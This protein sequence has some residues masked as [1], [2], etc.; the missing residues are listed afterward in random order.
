MSHSAYASGATGDPE[1]RGFIEDLDAILAEMDLSTGQ[2]TFVSRGAERLLGYPVERWYQDPEMWAMLLHPEDRVSALA[3]CQRETAAGRDHRMEYR[4]IT[5]DGRVV[6]IHDDVHIGFDAAGQPSHLRCVM[7][8]VTDRYQ[9]SEALRVSERW[10]RALN[11]HALDIVTVLSPQGVILYESPSLE[12]VLGFRPE[13]MVGRNAFEVLHPDDVAH[14]LAVFRDVLEHRV[15]T[16][17][18]QFRFPHKA[19]GWR[20]IEAYGR[21]LTSD[22]A[23]GGMVVNSRDVTDRH[24]AEQSLR[25]SETRYR[26]VVG[27]LSEGIVLM[28]ASGTVRASNDAAARIF[29]QSL[30][31]F[32][33]PRPEEQ[34]ISV[35]REDGSL[36]PFEERPPIR[37]LRERREVRDC[38]LG[39][40]SDDTGEVRWLSVHAHPLPAIDSNEPT[41]AV[42]SLTDITEQRRLQEVLVHTQKMEAVGRF[43]GG[44]AHDFNNLLTAVRGYSE[45]LLQTTDTDSPQHGY[46]DQ[47]RSAAERATT[48]TRQLLTFSRKHAVELEVLDLHGV[49][50]D[51]GSMIRG[52]L[53]ES[54]VF[55]TDLSSTQ[56]RVNMDHGQLEQLLL[57]LVINA[58]DASPHGG[59]VTIATR[60]VRLTG[61]ESHLIRAGRE[62]D[63]V[64]L[65]VRDTGIG[66]D[67][68]TLRHIFEPFYTTKPH[69]KGTGLG[70]ASVYGVVQQACGALAV[71]SEPQQGAAFHIYLPITL[72][73]AAPRHVGSPTRAGEGG[74]ERVLLVEDEP[75]VR[76]LVGSVLGASGYRVTPA[77]DGQEALQ[78]LADHPEG[79]DLLLTDVVMPGM[80][81]FELAER[82]TRRWPATAVLHMSGHT[83]A[84]YTPEAGSRVG[85]SLLQKP[86]TPADLLSQVRERLDS[87]ATRR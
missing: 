77:A 1:F 85:Y 12:R 69:G 73:P 84:E 40:R 38:V 80:S 63:Y 57:N 5:A 23:V 52:L 39:M 29:G 31:Q 28:D 78:L 74:C 76:E 4:M 6:W 11:E 51:L 87:A 27:A 82:L 14:T 43:A 45:M 48:L 59:E 64:E 75:M 47:I 83:N 22:P 24:E 16:G 46:A 25:E 58:R 36:M 72:Q 55:K 26:T 7:F 70:L 15:E 79:F 35:I 37:A 61:Q 3:C 41:L 71:V 44:V 18:V 49:L 2:F 33:G 9:A 13:E 53:G 65:T 10:N 17:R 60:D 32:M 19:G 81:G 62:G 56:A 30:N 50:H 34:G 68:E 66:M 42:A 8:D 21:D 20:M 54:I 67:H 86:F